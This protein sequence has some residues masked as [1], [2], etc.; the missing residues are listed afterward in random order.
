[1]YW[2]YCSDLGVIG[3]EKSPD[4]TRDPLSAGSLISLDSSISPKSPLPI[5]SSSCSSVITGTLCELWLNTL[6]NFFMLLR[7]LCEWPGGRGR[8]SWSA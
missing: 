3:K 4:D 7:E 8:A 5:D 1:M 2:D 6:S